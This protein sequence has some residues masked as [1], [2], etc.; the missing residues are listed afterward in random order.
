MIVRCV[1]NQGES[2]P[3]TEYR[4]LY[5]TESTTFDVKPGRD[6]VVHAMALFNYGLIVLLADETERPNWYPI[7]LFEVLDDSLPADWHVAFTGGGEGD[8]QALWGYRALIEDPTHYEGLI[9]R[10]PS[11]MRDFWDAASH[12]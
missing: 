7:E 6:Y 3:A 9:E 10:E 11:A 1:R 12:R 4:G 8:L 5:Y 2:P